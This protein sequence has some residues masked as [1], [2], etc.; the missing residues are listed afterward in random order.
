MEPR[1]VNTPPAIDASSPSLLLLRNTRLLLTAGFG[2]LLLLMSFSG[3]DAVRVLRSIQGRNDRIR[4]DF[5]DRN[6]LLNQIRSDLYL[7]G[8]YVRDYLLE[9]ESSNA[10]VHR[11]SLDRDRN[12][13]EMALQ[14]YALRLTPNEVEPYD[15]LRRELRDYWRVL[16]PVMRWDPEQRR[17]RS[18]AFLRDEVF[19]RRMAML[20][21]ADQIARVN[22]QQ[23]NDGNAQVASLFSQFRNRLGGTVIAT[24]G[25][26]LLLAALSMNV[27][28]ASVKKDSPEY[29]LFKQSV[30]ALSYGEGATKFWREVNARGKEIIEP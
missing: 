5:L 27:P 4:A 11:A 7:S 19:P 8:T 1:H 9:P 30:H 29:F 26:G 28:E 24:L 2:G 15:V 20:T 6:R 22:E 14:A 21:I 25:L 17:A 18:Y 13:M 3:I 10:D 16:E 23:L 12:D